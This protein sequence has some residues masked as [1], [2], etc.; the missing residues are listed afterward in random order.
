MTPTENT[1][2]SDTPRRQEPEDKGRGRNELQIALIGAAA[3][4]VA[5]VI[6]GLLA[7]G[8]SS[9]DTFHSDLQV[10]NM[11]VVDRPPNATIGQ[12]Y[13]AADARGVTFTLRNPGNGISVIT[14]ARF[15]VKHFA[16]L[17]TTGC[18]PGA[19]PIPV[20]A[21]YQAALPPMA[22]PG[23]AI[24][25]DFSEQVSANSADRFSIGFSF[26][27]S[28]AYEYPY[29]NGDGT[30][31]SRLYELEVELFH[32]SDTAPLRAGTILLALPFPAYEFFPGGTDTGLSGACASKNLAILRRMLSL[33]GARSPELEAF[34]KDPGSEVCA[35]ASA[36]R[37]LCKE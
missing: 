17:G 1:P 3:V 32:D 15:I 2:P 18:I 30:G 29:L 33:K 28:D 14:S 21:D 26:V 11:A 5:A 27:T 6:G 22:R 7:R 35:S 9:A 25:A 23:E 31:A 16:A 36:E 4:L 19:G 37:A 12:T 34:G 10:L 13:K 8:G 24:N 20:A